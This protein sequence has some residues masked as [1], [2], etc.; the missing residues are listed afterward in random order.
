MGISILILV[1][2]MILLIGGADWLV[3][4]VAALAA[5]AGVSQLIIGLTVVAFGTSTPELVVNTI[6][7][8]HGQT[9]LAFGNLVGS[10][11]INVGFVLALTAIIRPLKVE[12][13]IITREIPMMLLG[14]ASLVVMSSDITLNHA[15]ADVLSRGDGLI[16][17]LL[18]CVFLYYIFMGART[19]RE[20]DAFVAQSGAEMARRKDRPIYVDVLMT[21]AGLVGV[22]AGGRMTVSGAVSVA[23]AMGIS[24][25]IIGLTIISFGTTL[26]ELTTSLLAARRGHADIA[27]GNVIGSNIYNLL[28]VG[29][30]VATV[31]PIHLPDGGK[32]DLL[33]MALLCAS[34]LPIAIRGPR[35]ITRAEGALL[36][37]TY[38]AYVI[39]RARGGTLHAT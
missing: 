14:V 13:S 6:S 3:R 37:C 34:M 35:K 29:G 2:G 5:E 36:L 39:F 7:A 12:P 8:W 30:I 33:V 16:L 9:D 1:V 27:I 17:L 32:L 4:G 15:D 24:E 31:H 22:G 19:R 26:P 25:T 21:L 23:H 10:C 38:M 11:S 28:C 20:G 18:F